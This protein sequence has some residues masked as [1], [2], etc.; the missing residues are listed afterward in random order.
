MKNFKIGKEI[1]RLL[2]EGNAYKIKDKVFPL[3]ANAN[4]TFPFLV[5]RRIGYQ[6]RNNKDYIGE[7]VTM[8]INIATETYNEGVEIANS[9]ADIL[10]GQSTD[11]IEDIQLT[12][13][14]EL[15]LQDT[16]IQS[17]QF[18]GSSS[19]YFENSR[20]RSYLC[21]RRKNY[22]YNSNNMCWKYN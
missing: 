9:V 12:N 13:V 3:V 19:L 14:N 6:P 11:L 15:F 20:S 16:F 2:Q 18:L 17:L 22:Q 4:T 7:I 10:Q 1:N 8:E 5:Y 21:K